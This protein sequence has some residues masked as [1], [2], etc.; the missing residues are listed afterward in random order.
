MPDEALS[1]PT[2]GEYDD[3]KETI[4]VVKTIGDIKKFL[5]TRKAILDREPLYLY[6]KSQLRERGFLGPWTFNAAQSLICSIPGL[7]LSSLIWIVFGPI[8]SP[9]LGTDDDPIATSISAWINPLRGPFTLLAIVYVVA[10][11]CL[12]KR[13]TTRA[14]LHAGARKYL[15]FDATYGFWAQ[16][17]FAASLP[18]YSIPIAAQKKHVTALILAMLGPAGVTATFSWQ[19]IVTTWRT[20]HELFNF[21]YLAAPSESG[22]VKKTSAIR[23]FAVVGFDLPAVL[24]VEF[25]VVRI[26]VAILA[27]AVHFLRA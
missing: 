1:P 24:V 10:F 19:A 27:S 7:I 2:K 17:W 15:Y 5:K 20:G 22:D 23:F 25:V 26:I 12:P 16:L 13:N 11:A 6:T 4:P 14:N 9:A 21:D 18:L 3:P 8:S